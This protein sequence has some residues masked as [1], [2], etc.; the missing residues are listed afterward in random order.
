MSTDSLYD[1]RPYRLGKSTDTKEK[2]AT[3]RSLLDR[4]CHHGV[5][6]TDRSSRDLVVEDPEEWHG[7]RS[8]VVL[9]VN[10]VLCGNNHIERDQSTEKDQMTYEQE[11]PNFDVTCKDAKN[12]R[13]N[14]SCEVHD[15]QIQGNLVSDVVFCIVV[16]GVGLFEDQLAVLQAAECVGH[17][18]ELG[19]VRYYAALL[20]Q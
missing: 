1:E 13:R 10:V 11:L 18:A 20:C 14:S 12:Q 9:C 6:Q 8:F 4:L 2:A 15:Q 17:Q 7:D 5:R 16:F 3:E 19:D